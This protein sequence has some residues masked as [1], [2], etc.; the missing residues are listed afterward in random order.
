V[1]KNLKTGM[2][3]IRSQYLLEYS[4]GSA[5]F[6]RKNFAIPVTLCELDAAKMLGDIALPAIADGFTSTATFF[7]NASATTD[8][9]DTAPQDGYD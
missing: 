9:T 6:Q 1:Q 8:S 3:S 4:I 5:A 7:L 2:K